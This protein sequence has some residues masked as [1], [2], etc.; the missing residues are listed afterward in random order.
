[1][2]AALGGATAEEPEA[3]TVVRRLNDTLLSVL[4][5]AQRLGYEGRRARLAPAVDAAYDVPF[6]AEKALGRHWK[7]LSDA[8]RARWISLSRQFSTAN[9][10]ANFGHWSGQTIDLLGQ[11]G[12]ASDTVIVRT[13][14]NDPQGEGVD[15]SYRLHRTAE[16]WRIIDVY[17]KGTVSELALRRS[18]YAGV[19]ERDGFETLATTMESRIAGLASA[20]AAR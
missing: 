3:T 5:D 4:K 1:V 18:D 7:T 13:R 9:Y 8:D 12:A 17:L 6:M 10:A 2:L 11:D 15:M 20:K 19:L 16:G 14:I